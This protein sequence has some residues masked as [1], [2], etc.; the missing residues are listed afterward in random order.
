MMSA[1]RFERIIVV[2]DEFTTSDRPFAL[3]RRLAAAGILSVEVL[4]GVLDNDQ[5]GGIPGWR[6]Q[7]RLDSYGLSAAELYVLR[8]QDPQL[9]V[10]EHLAGHDGSLILRGTSA[11]GHDGGPLL[12]HTA[13][14]IMSHVPQPLLLLGPRQANPRRDGQLSPITVRDGASE[15]TSLESATGRWISTF[16]N[17]QPQFVDVIPP[18]PWPRSNIQDVDNPS[19]TPPRTDHTELRTLD[20]GAALLSHLNS[21]HDAVVVV[22]SPRWPSTPSHWWSTARRLVRQLSCPVLVVPAVGQLEL[23]PAAGL[24]RESRRT[25]G[26]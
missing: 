24:G 1:M 4:Y 9:A 22:A 16:S 5:G 7:H 26:P 19:E 25:A 21:R 6:L 2:A 12:D 14:A 8:A 23:A 15:L 10:C 11:G 20:L 18:D 13:E 3:A 17:I